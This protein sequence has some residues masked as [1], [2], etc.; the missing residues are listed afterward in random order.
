MVSG[1]LA[2]RG[3]RFAVQRRWV[4]QTALHAFHE[5]K[6]GKLVEFAGYAMPVQYKGENGG[7]IKET[8]GTR[9]GAGLFDVSHM[10]QLRFEGKDRVDF[11][12]NV[13]VSS[14]KALK[15]GQGRYTLITNDKG[16]LIDDAIV[17]RAASD[18][19][20]ILVVNAARIKEDLAHLDAMI[21]AFDGEVSYTRLPKSLLALQG[22]KA[23]GIVE[24][25]SQQDLSQVGFFDAVP[26][27]LAL[28]DGSSADVVATRSGYTGE[29][30]FEISID[31]D[32]AAAL[33]QTLS[34]QEGV[35]LA[36]LGA[37]DALRL[38]AGLCLYG[39]DLDEETTP[40]EADL[41][42]TISKPR[43]RSC[44]FPGGDVVRGQIEGTIPVE[45]K[46]VGLLL[47]GRQAA[48][49]GAVLMH[50]DKE[51]GEV[52]SGAFSPTLQRP[53]A[54]AYVH[55][56]YAAIGTELKAVVR[57]KELPATVSSMPFVP[58]NYYKPQ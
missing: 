49:S 28:S 4:L 19:H 36:G 1:A 23:A 21:A 38:E 58:T 3:A 13:V 26:L 42:W 6:G 34:E 16:G 2:R 17:T 41:L 14:V 29:D 52:T 18:D 45:K 51:V 50:D 44:P 46:R 47:E 5:E 22:P 54:M 55:P 39:N 20:H 15:P 33:A 11:L 56:D 7:V 31:E 53:V 12:S 10:G 43:R 8:L 27:T 30:G 32:K 35:V 25:L 40:V 37:R 9:N 48:R 24:K 57:N